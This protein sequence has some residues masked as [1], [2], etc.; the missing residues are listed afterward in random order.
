MTTTTVMW[1][2]VLRTEIKHVL[3]LLST[4]LTVC[5]YKGKFSCC[6]IYSDDVVVVAVLLGKK[7]VNDNCLLF[8][9]SVSIMIMR[10]TVTYRLQFSFK[11][12]LPTFSSSFYIT[13]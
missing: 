6:R 12:F 8:F 3:S 7:G 9:L 10:K 13:V 4:T 1:T 2:Y 11:K 5:T